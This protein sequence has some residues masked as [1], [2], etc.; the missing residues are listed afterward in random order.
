MCKYQYNGTCPAPRPQGARRLLYALPYQL[1]SAAL[2][3]S[4]P[5][6]QLLVA[7]PEPRGDVR[8]VCE[9]GQGGYNWT[10]AGEQLCPCPSTGACVE[11]GACA[12]GPDKKSCVRPGP[13]GGSATAGPNATLPAGGTVRSGLA[14]PSSPQPS[15]AGEVKSS[16]SSTHV[17]LLVATAVL[18]VVI[19]VGAVLV[20][21]KLCFASP[22][23][24]RVGK[25][26]APGAA[27]DS[28]PEANLTESSSED[29]LEARRPQPGGDLA[30][31]SQG[32]R[33]PEQGALPGN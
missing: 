3:F 29:S 4:P 13:S 18:T 7:C 32:E 11:P 31:S 19:L 20:L 16:A 9:R 21:F 10:G 6:T 2:D 27:V 30:G 26:P 25:E 14:A 22:S 1:H 33:N 12:P 24:S 17:F 8:L 15:A 28:D 5:G 23:A